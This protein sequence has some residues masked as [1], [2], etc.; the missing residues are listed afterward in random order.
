MAD[1]RPNPALND[2]ERFALLRCRSAGRLDSKGDEYGSVPTDQE[3][4]DELEASTRRIPRATWARLVAARLV[5]YGDSR[6]RIT[7][8]GRRALRGES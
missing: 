7:D 2:A 5:T 1:Q 6:Y 4:R 8:A 3:R